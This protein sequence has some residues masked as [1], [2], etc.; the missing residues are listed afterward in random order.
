MQLRAYLA[1]QDIT[2]AAFADALGVSIQA[3]HRYLNGERLPKREVMARI[4]CVTKGKVQ[5]NDF[6]EPA[7][8]A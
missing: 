2:I 1:T 6:F 7:E 8:A 3:V 5:P 4:A